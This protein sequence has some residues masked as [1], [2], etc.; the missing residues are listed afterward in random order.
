MFPNQL[1]SPKVPITF[2]NRFL[3]QI[4]VNR[5]VI[6]SILE[7]AG[8]RVRQ[9]KD[10]PVDLTE[11]RVVLVWGNANWYQGLY[12]QLKTIPRGERPLVVL[13]HSEALPP[14]RAA[15]LPWPRLNWWE[16][17]KFL[18][19]DSRATDVYTNYL[20]LRHWLKHGLPDILVAAT[21]GRC[22]FLNERGMA[23]DWVPLG[24]EPSWCGH[25]LGLTRDIEVLFLGALDV[26]RRNRLLRRLRNQG[27]RIRPVGSYVDPSCWGDQRTK[28][29]N[30]TKI[31]LSLARTRGE[32][33]DHRLILGMANKALVISEPIYRPAPFVPGRHFISVSIEEMPE[34][35]R[36]YL[37]HDEERVSITE[38]AYDLVTQD[39]TMERSVGQIVDLINHAC[40]STRPGDSVW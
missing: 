22:E 32:F 27:I 40:A 38:R 11:D 37:T 30:R 2:C 13:W 18:L 12:T 23:A 35:I 24:Y 4:W 14:P 16:A 9:I 26:P 15:K 33:P 6:V 36:Y 19:R 29:L 17:G 34:K 10:G 28:L 25:D 20:K 7:N 5:H 31:L 8:H 3:G 39:V 21:P 1:V